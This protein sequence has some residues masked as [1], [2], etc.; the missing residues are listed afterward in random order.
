MIQRDSTIICVVLNYSQRCL[1]MLCTIRERGK[2]GATVPGKNAAVGRNLKQIQIII[3]SCMHYV[4]ATQCVF[5][6]LAG[7]SW[8]KVLLLINLITKFLWFQLKRNFPLQISIFFPE[9]VPCFMHLSKCTCA[10][11]TITLCHSIC[12]YG[13]VKMEW[14]NC[15]SGTVRAA[16]S[17]TR[18]E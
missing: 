7:E 5:P 12:L 16:K 14:C 1:K 6:Y 15:S 13:T 4:S 11:C 3:S 17:S 18:P 9:F 8:L 2:H 10:I